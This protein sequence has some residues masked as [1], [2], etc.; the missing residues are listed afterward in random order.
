MRSDRTTQL[1]MH[2]LPLSVALGSLGLLAGFVVYLAAGPIMANDFW[3]HLKLGEIYWAEGP[4]LESDPFVYTS[5]GRAPD[6]HAWLF[7]VALYAIESAA[8]LQGVRIAHALAVA[9]IL[10]LAYTSFRRESGSSIAVCFATCVFVGLSWWRLIQLRPD[11]VSILAVL[12]LHRLLL[13]PEPAPSWKR[14]GASLALLVVWANSHALFALGPCLLVVALAGFALQAR[15]LRSVAGGEAEAARLGPAAR[16]VAAA[17][18]LGSCA[19]LFNPKGLEQYLSFVSSAGSSALWKIGDEWTPFHPFSWSRD[20]GGMSFPAWL[21]TDA[22]LLAFLL[23]AGAVLWRFFRRPSPSA[24]RSVDLVGLGLG[25][26]SVGAILVSFRFLWL[27]FFPLLFLL[28]ALRIS[29]EE[30][31]RR[32]PLAERALAAGS[33]A[34]AVVFIGPGGLRSVAAGLPSG[35]SEYLRG[36]YDPRIYHV[37]GVRFLRETGVEGNLFNAYWMGGFLGYWLAPKLRTFVDGRL[38]FPD[39]ILDEYFS[40]NHL[41]GYREGESFLDV[42]ERRQVDLFLGVRYPLARAPGSRRVYTTAH[43]E[44]ARDWIL[45]SR[46][47]HHAIYLRDND[48]NRENLH[49]VEAYYARQG[50]PFDPVRGFDAGEVIRLHP[51]WAARHGMLPR[52]QA[53]LSE[54]RR[55]PDP[56]VRFHALDSLGLVYA[57]VG[58]YARQVDIDREAAALRPRSNAPR[59]RLVNGLLRL[60]RPAE[61]LA[62]ARDL[63]RIDP[64]DPRYARVLLTARRAAEGGAPSKPE[65][66]GGVS[67]QQR[68]HEL[69]V[70]SW[71]ELRR[72]Q[73]RF[74]WGMLEAE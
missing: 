35:A 22:L 70:V 29:L 21:T 52:D 58:D 37:D 34:L 19:A 4:W 61:A 26:A 27:S 9:G 46:S 17:T 8:G 47:I 30:H 10:W 40:V 11:L 65:T 1:L 36:H 33:L 25:A 12:L 32:E 15:I 54:A 6:P 64:A 66:P 39:E 69:P 49:R 16:R 62:A 42:L 68:I 48:R 71:P 50:I 56:D 2:W 57:L 59:R 31:A 24:L 53:R 67:L 28:R 18:L 63:R 7:G 20:P 38:N 74:D 73:S 72:L 45:V 13:Q 23:V 60:G 55:S 51:S 3:W 5:Q 41:Q 14:I 44:G 43:L